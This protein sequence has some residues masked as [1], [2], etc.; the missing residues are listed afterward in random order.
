MFSQGLWVRTANVRWRWST[1]CLG[2]VSVTWTCIYLMRWNLMLYYN[3][4]ALM[5]LFFTRY[6]KWTEQTFPQGGKE[7]NH[8]TLLERA[9]TKFTEEKKYHNDPRYVDLWIKFVWVFYFYFYES[10]R[11]AVLTQKFSWFLFY[12]FTLCVCLIRQRPARSP[13]TFTTTWKPRE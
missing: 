10:A 6:I 13:W 11:V 2:S 3:V 12:F 7:S 5:A 8:A 1:W 9:V 4:I